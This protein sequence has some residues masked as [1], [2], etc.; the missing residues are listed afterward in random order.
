VVRTAR[1]PRTVRTRRVCAQCRLYLWS[2]AP[3]LS[4]HRALR[5]V[6][7][8]FD[9]WDNRDRRASDD[10]PGLKAKGRLRW[11]TAR[12]CVQQAPPVELDRTLRAA[13][14]RIAS[15]SGL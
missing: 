2:D 9:R 3:G 8:I 1:S 15:A 5:R 7:Y 14:L 12:T 4:A 13:Q 11:A 6:G 10:A